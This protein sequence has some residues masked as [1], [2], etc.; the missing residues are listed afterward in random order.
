MAA[1]TDT[2]SVTLSN[3]CIDRSTL[4]P[5]LCVVIA[6]LTNNSASTQ[7][8][9]RTQTP[10]SSALRHS[11]FT[12][13]SSQ[14]ASTASIAAHIGSSL[15]RL[16]SLRSHPRS[17]SNLTPQRDTTFVCALQIV[18]IA[19]HPRNIMH[20]RS[21]LRHRHVWK[22]SIIPVFDNPLTRH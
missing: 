1:S 11:S 19:R 15:C 3:H 13:A 7:I 5:S 10:H 12:S 6:A 22:M 18:C 16:C 4:C 2:H 8:A 17:H 21:A 14:R 20:S 9:L